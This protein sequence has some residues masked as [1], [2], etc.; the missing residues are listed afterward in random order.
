MRL[1]Q[2]KVRATLLWY[3]VCLSLASGLDRLPIFFATVLPLPLVSL[4]PK[5]ARASHVDEAPGKTAIRGFS[6]A[7][8]AVPRAPA[9]WIKDVLTALDDQ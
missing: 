6:A 3:E 5:P 4:P 2:G 9:L 1:S 8:L 7:D